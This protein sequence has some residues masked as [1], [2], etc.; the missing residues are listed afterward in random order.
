[1]AG[2]ATTV[3]FT[4]MWSV[5][6]RPSLTRTTKESLPTKSLAGV[7]DSETFAPVAG[8]PATAVPWAGADE[9]AQESGLPSA[10]VAD[11]LAA[12]AVGKLFCEIVRGM[13]AP[14]AMTGGAF[15]GIRNARITAMCCILVAPLSPESTGETSDSGV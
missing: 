7:Y 5:P 6:P 11:R 13:A 8:D 12:K 1:M 4:I 10:S 14:W 9:M 2:T 3:T 15:V